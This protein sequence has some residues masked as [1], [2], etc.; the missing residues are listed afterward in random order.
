MATL[1][2]LPAEIQLHIINELI[3][4]GVEQQVYY[5][6]RCQIFVQE[7]P[8]ISMPLTHVNLF[9]MTEVANQFRKTAQYWHTLHSKGASNT[10]GF[11]KDFMKVFWIA[12]WG[13][14][15]KEVARRV[16]QPAVTASD[17]ETEGESSLDGDSD[18]EDG[19]LIGSFF[20]TAE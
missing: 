10:L 11:M 13:T 1:M 15:G 16:V 18:W 17:A 7:K 5:H 3:Y 19:D 2:A 20:E 6:M 9:F 4:S 8:I 14:F 12:Q